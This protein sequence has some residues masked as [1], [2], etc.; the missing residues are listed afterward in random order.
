M[1]CL[2]KVAKTLLSLLI[3]GALCF[4]PQAFAQ[5]ATSPDTPSAKQPDPND[6]WHADITPYMWFAGVHGTA[7]VL[8][9]DASVHASFGG[10]LQ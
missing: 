7:G 4:S 10:H 9:H 2:Y 3:L 8:G 1:P 6:G 5:S